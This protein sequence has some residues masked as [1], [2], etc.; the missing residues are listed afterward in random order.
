[1][2]HKMLTSTM[3]TNNNFK[4][5]NKTMTE[6]YL[7]RNVFK[8]VYV[9]CINHTKMHKIKQDALIRFGNLF[10]NFEDPQSF[11]SVKNLRFNCDFYERN[12][13]LK[14]DDDY[15][16]I[17]SILFIEASFYFICKKCER[18]RFDEF[19]MSLEIKP[20]VPEQYVLLK[21]SDLVVTKT[22]EQKCIGNKIFIL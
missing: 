8:S 10:Q 6:K 12:L 1:M 19:L 4:W 5:L 22:H 9:D 2:K 15:F 3:K 7:H 21:H 14:H 18:I 16:I 11:Q 20:S 17:E 13:V